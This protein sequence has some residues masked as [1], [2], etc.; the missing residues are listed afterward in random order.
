MGTIAGETQAAAAGR[1]K[2][3]SEKSDEDGVAVGETDG[4]AVD[5]QPRRRIS[6][7]APA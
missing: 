1:V 6:G 4:A 7:H 5:R 2:S 3:V